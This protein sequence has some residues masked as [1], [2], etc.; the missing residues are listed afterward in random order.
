MKLL[1]EFVRYDPATGLFYWRTRQ[2]QEP[3]AQRWNG[4]CAGKQISPNGLG[5]KF[6]QIQVRPGLKYSVTHARAAWAFMTGDYP[7]KNLQIDHINGD[8]HDNRFINLRCV[9]NKQNCRNK[10]VCNSNTGITG[11]SKC[12][13]TEVPTY[14]VSI[15]AP[16]RGGRR[17]TRKTLAAA[18]RLRNRWK[19]EL[20]YTE[21]HGSSSCP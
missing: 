14:K 3:G 12:A 11:I 17:A 9:T 16:A 6:V 7:P 13:K 4:R 8:K 2:S 10:D 19:R 1:K 21:R 5:Y 20:G 15:G 18:I